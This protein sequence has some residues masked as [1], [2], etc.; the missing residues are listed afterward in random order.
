MVT[1]IMDFNVSR[2]CGCDHMFILT[3]TSSLSLRPYDTRPHSQSP[4]REG[5]LTG[6]GWPGAQITH[7]DT[8]MKLPPGS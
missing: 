4:G 8:G 7:T 5:E 6:G 2:C 1:L 3:E